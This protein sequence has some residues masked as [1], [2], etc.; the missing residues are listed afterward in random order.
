MAYPTA[1]LSMTLN[2]PYPS[3]KVTPLFDAEYLQNGT[4]YTHNFN[5]IILLFL[6]VWVS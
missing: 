1:P 2:D 6:L 5:E 4:R 3:F